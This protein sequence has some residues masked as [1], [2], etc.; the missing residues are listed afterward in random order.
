MSRPWPITWHPAYRSELRCLSRHAREAR[1][2]RAATL[3]LESAGP[4]LG[5]PHSSA[6]RGSRSGLR[7]LRPLAGRSPWRVLYARRGDALILL[8]LAP[9]AMHDPRGFRAAVARAESRLIG[10]DPDR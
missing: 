6:V 5:F 8:A 1:Q 9:E 2:I 10:L 4:A 3:K 7:E